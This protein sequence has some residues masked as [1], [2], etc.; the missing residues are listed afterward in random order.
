LMGNDATN[1][2]DGGSGNDFLDGGPGDDTLF[3]GAGNDIYIIG[4]LS[5]IVDEQGNSD[6]GDE[7]RTDAFSIALAAINGG[8]IEHATLL[9]GTGFSISGTALSNRLTGNSADNELD[10]AGGNDTLDGGVGEDTLRGG[11]GNDVYV[12]D[13]AGDI[14]DEQGNDSGDELR[15]GAFSI[16]LVTFA[17]GK[18]EHATLLGSANLDI[19]GN[20]AANILTGNSGKNI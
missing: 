15:T 11:S 17:S 7:I 4:A 13:S 3:G 10:G 6:T 12:V 18:F 14:V 1:L 20:F 5:D 8:S 19:T 16:D 2:L 9:G